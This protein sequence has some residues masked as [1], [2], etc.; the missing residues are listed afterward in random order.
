MIYL[1]DE[2][3]RQFHT[4]N[5]AIALGKFDGV[6][7][8]H[9]MLI[10]QM[11]REKNKGRTTLVFTFGS[12]PYT[13][14]SGASQKVIYTSEEKAYYFSTLG[15]D[16]LL[17][18]PFTKEFAGIS[19][20]DFTRDCLSTQLGVRSIY[21]G[22]DFHFGKG[23]SGNVGLLKELSEQYYFEVHD[24]PKKT[25]HGKVVSSTAVR[26]M[27]ESKFHVANEMLGNPY[28]VYGPVIHGMHMGHTIGFPT[29]NQE[30]PA[31]KLTPG[32]GVYASRVTVGDNVY[33]AISNLGAKPTVIDSHHVGL[34][35]HILDFNG[36]LYDQYIKTELLFYIRPEEK[37]KDVDSL[38]KQIRDD[39]H[40]MLDNESDGL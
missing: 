38:K 18:Y 16:V 36:D 37:F 23:R 30:I 15:V 4:N 11:L 1:R 14:L 33:R 21:V 6:H 22:E 8:G 27:L 12:S 9:Q 24:L 28:Y 13:I 7:L 19:P 31:N 5:T 34:E 10:S 29:I 26:D 20:E 3:A 40:M 35:T 17:E 32:L 25:L 39:I 2:E